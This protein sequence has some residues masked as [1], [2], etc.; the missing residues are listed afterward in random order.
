MFLL[1]LSF[2]YYF[3]YTIWDIVILSLKWPYWLKSEVKQTFYLLTYL[4]FRKC[5][6]SVP[7]G[8]PYCI[9]VL[10]SDLLYIV[11]SLTAP[12]SAVK[13]HWAFT[14]GHLCIICVLSGINCIAITHTITRFQLNSMVK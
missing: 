5:R 12:C 3:N 6:R 8:I 14:S 9:L 11:T 4:A 7:L 10:L 2:L 1:A 13:F